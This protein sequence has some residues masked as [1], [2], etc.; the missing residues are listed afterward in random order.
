MVWFRCILAELV[1]FLTLRLEKIILINSVSSSLTKLAW[2]YIY[3]YNHIPRISVHTNCLCLC[4][5]IHP[6]HP[7]LQAG[8][9]GNI[10]CPHRKSVNL[11]RSANTCTSVCRS[12]SDNFAY[13]FI[14][15]SPAV[16]CMSCLSH[17]NGLWDRR[18][19]S[20]QQLFCGTAHNIL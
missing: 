4:P 20:V 5:S 9:R 8:S 11:W 16:L 14:F 15:A 6:N 18:Q 19:V 1:L 2:I 10:L 12:S 13:E 17:L 3:V 7:S